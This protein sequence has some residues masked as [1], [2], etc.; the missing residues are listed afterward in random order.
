MKNPI[1]RI[2]VVCLLA[3]FG[4]MLLAAAPK[5]RLSNASIG[6][7]DIAVG[8]NGAQ[9]TVEAS[10]AGDG[11][12]DLAVVSPDEWLAPSLGGARP[13]TSA[14]G[15]CIPIQIAL[16]TAGL[17]QG[18]HTGYVEVTD[19]G[20][21]DAPQTVTVTVQ[22]GGGVPDEVRLWVP[23]EGADSVKFE[24]NSPITANTFTQT[25]G[26]WLSVALEGA[27]SFSFAM[28]YRIAARDLPAL[29]PGSYEGTVNVTASGFA[30]NVK[31]V[32]VTMQVT[33]EP[34]SM[35]SR[36]KVEFRLAGGT[37]PVDGFVA[38]SNRGLGE[39]ELEEPAVSDGEA[40]WLSAGLL[41]GFVRIRADPEGLA[42][43]L[44]RG[45]VSV[46]S[47]A[48]NSPQQ[49]AVRL[50]VVR[51]GPPIAS[52]NGVVNNATFSSEDPVPQGG[53][54]AVFGS[55]LSFAPPAIGDQL[56]LVR[57]LGGTRV[58]VNGVD[59]PLFFS[60][61]GQVNFQMPYE[62][63]PG[64][65]RVQVERDGEVGNTVT[66][67]VAEKSPRILT[68]LDNYAIA[69]NTDQTFAVP[70]T[71]GL[72]SRP[73]RPGDT[74]VMYAIG[75]GA[76]VPAVATGAAAPEEPLAHVSPTPQLFLGGGILR[77]EVTPSFAGLTPGFVG[78]F[79]INFT[80]PATAPRGDRIPLFLQGPGYTTNVVNIAIE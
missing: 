56:P 22:I 67:Q 57:G 17:S 16:E 29:P 34:I 5:L 79:Q 62:T 12:L 46:S 48:A 80:I 43:G 3:I 6:P 19:P 64:E 42:P 37:T 40:G 33:A 18:S 71:P 76:T 72:D 11:A 49:I 61:E 68:I 28:P 26:E 60:S 47:N 9:Q 69:A 55:L 63:A 58:L 21:I 59:T 14:L 35:L 41:P 50:E 24:T 15:T 74:L 65:A 7:I 38:I 32:P 30:G 1:Y 10:N 36:D 53:I 45:S 75:F 54:A 8:E 51:Q 23:P 70:A 2:L 52:F 20:A 27:G 44:Y 73:A 77:T 66:V 4:E 39:L 25:G 13:C 31:S 78:L